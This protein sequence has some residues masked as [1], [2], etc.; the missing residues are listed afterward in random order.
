[1]IIQILLVALCLLVWCLLAMSGFV[2]REQLHEKELRELR[3][4]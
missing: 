1:M 3:K 4:R 2:D